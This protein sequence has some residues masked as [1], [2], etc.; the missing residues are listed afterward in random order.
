[1]LSNHWIICVSEAQAKVM[2]QIIPGLQYDSHEDDDAV[3]DDNDDST[4]NDDD[5]S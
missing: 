4:D 3:P 5:Q 1:M 2:M